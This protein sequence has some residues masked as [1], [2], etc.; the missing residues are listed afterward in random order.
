MHLAFGAVSKKLAL[1]NSVTIPSFNSRILSYCLIVLILRAI[2]ITVQFLYSVN[3]T[4]ANTFSVLELKSKI[5]NL[6]INKK[7]IQK[8]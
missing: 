6:W 4:F 8:P 1:S 5:N 2:F 7:F 3:R